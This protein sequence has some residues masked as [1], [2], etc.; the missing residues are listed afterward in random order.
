MEKLITFD[1]YETLMDTDPF[2][3]AIAEVGAKVGEDIAKVRNTYLSWED[4]IMYGTPFIRYD[5]LVRKALA[6][7]ESDLNISGLVEQSDALL[8][9]MKSIKP[10]SDVKDGLRAIKE[11]GYKTCVM[12]NSVHDIM[13][14]HVAAMEHEFDYL[15]L[16]EDLHCYKPRVEFFTQAAE[17]LQ[18][19]N[20]DTHIHIA[21]GFWW[22]IMPC[23]EVGWKRK[24][25]V[26]RTGKKGLSEYLPYQEVHSLEEAIA[27]I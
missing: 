24:I 5:E 17:K 14:H 22:D 16:A 8:D 25:W 3:D 19:H 4:R 20:Q 2:F 10:F 21:A 9:A 6:L 27:Y 13:K 12:S 15:M 26:N 23:T 18:V 7:T 1:C 11:K